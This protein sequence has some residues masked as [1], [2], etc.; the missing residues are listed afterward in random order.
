MASDL[1]CAKATSHVL[2][3]ECEVSPLNA[4]ACPCQDSHHQGPWTTW[5]S[6]LASNSGWSSNDIS[7]NTVIVKGHAGARWPRA[8]NTTGGGLRHTDGEVT[9][10]VLLGFETAAKKHCTEPQHHPEK[11]RQLQKSHQVPQHCQASTD[12][13]NNFAE[14]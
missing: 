5:S 10:A 8:M 3:L 11:N 2:F 7:N 1:H 4:S 6:Q 9:F 14:A 13:F 12:S